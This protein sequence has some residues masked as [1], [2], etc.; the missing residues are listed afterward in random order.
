MRR[1]KFV[2]VL[3]AVLLAVVIGCSKSD[4][5]STPEGGMIKLS[6][7]GVLGEYAASDTKGE[8]VNSMRVK[9]LSGDK[10]YVYDAQKCLGVLDV[11]PITDGMFADLSGTIQAPANATTVLTFVSG[12]SFTAT[13]GEELING[14]IEYDLSLQE[15]NKAP[16][17][18]YGTLPFSSASFSGQRVQFAFATS[19]I[20]VNCTGLKPE[21]DITKSEITGLNTVCVITV[22]GTGAPDVSGDT[23]A[24][25]VRTGASGFTKA[26]ANGTGT[27]SMAN[28]PTDPSDRLLKVYQS[29]EK[30]A[31]KF[32]KGGAL[33][34]NQSANTIVV[35]KKFFDI[36]VKS[37][38]DDW[39]TVTGGG[40]YYENESATL[41]AT[42]NEG[43][44][45]K[46]WIDASSAVVCSTAEFVIG[47]V[48]ADAEY[49]AVFEEDSKD[50]LGPLPGVFTAGVGP[51]G[52]AGTADDVK[53][54]F[55]QGNL[56][57]QASTNTWRFAPNQYDYIGDGGTNYGNVK[58]GDNTQI[59][60]NYDGWIDLFGWGTSGNSENRKGNECYQPW[61]S[62]T[63]ATYYYI[64]GVGKNISLSIEQKTDWG[65]NSIKVYDGDSYSDAQS[66]NGWRTLTGQ[67][68]NYIIGTST[69]TSCREGLRF[70]KCYLTVDEIKTYGLLIFPD[71]WQITDW[72]DGPAKDLYN[73]QGSSGYD[74]A[75]PTLDITNV[76]NDLQGK[77]VVFLPQTGYR[78]GTSLLQYNRCHYW[79]AN[80]EGNSSTYNVI[81]TYEFCVSSYYNSSIYKYYGKA[82]RLVTEVPQK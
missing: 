1:L 28:V 34:K 76:F 35:L 56:Q 64:N 29:G 58:Y 11:T 43:Y 48:T 54:Q 68:W 13:V 52:Q 65:Y 30:V 81:Y 12:S 47:S 44:K 46:Q 59:A 27:F 73:Q 23:P 82:V 3:W 7:T 33:N 77:G 10:V 17:M 60:E 14:R 31:G 78:N 36:T 63:N 79:A 18:V 21:A 42:P 69:K 45:F 67:E 55:S 8:L 57:Y 25:I 80:T 53:V 72:P 61:S 39:G 37:N 24:T 50:P 20:R 38:N 9:W 49:T 22:S 16:Y 2:S 66:I 15:G 26:D 70:I 71:G 5:N 51:D 40:M 62:S 41:T 6:L 32:T 19:V 75:P 4:E 74:N